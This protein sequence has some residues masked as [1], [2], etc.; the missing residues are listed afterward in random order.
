VTNPHRVT[1]FDSAEFRRVLGHVPTSVVVVTG[2][3]SRGAPAGVTIGSFVSISLEPPL[4]GFFQ[5]HGSASWAAIAESGCFSVNVLAASQQELCWR[6]AKE[7][8][9]G[10]SRFDGIEIDNAPNGSP[11]LPGGVASIDCDIEST[12]DIGDHLLVVGRVTALRAASEH[13]APMVFVRGAL[14]RAGVD[15]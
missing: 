7:P 11:L 9:A 3:D 14:G 15:T 4:V 10:T 5:G 6:F 8:A 1:P 2:R 13:D 12:L